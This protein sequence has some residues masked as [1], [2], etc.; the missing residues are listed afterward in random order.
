M[1]FQEFVDRESPCARSLQRVTYSEVI[2]DYEERE[3]ERSTT[4][5]RCGCVEDYW[6]PNG[7]KHPTDA[8]SFRLI[9]KCT[10]A[11]SIVK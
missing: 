7:S 2:L 8:K 5:W 9:K 4:I 1:S 6:Y 11:D 3:W 10:E